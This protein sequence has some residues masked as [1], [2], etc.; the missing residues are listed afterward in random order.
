MPV[1]PLTAFASQLIHMDLVFSLGLV[2]IFYF[3]IEHEFSRS[4]ENQVA[5][6]RQRIAL[7]VAERRARLVE[8]KRAVVEA[9][10]RVFSEA[11]VEVRPGSFEVISSDVRFDGLCGSL[12][13]MV[14]RRL[15]EILDQE[16]ARRLEDYLRLR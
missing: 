1:Q 4:R 3:I 9:L 7:D 11:V 12:K 5:L 14:G 15:L 2:Q 16:D 13:S 10:L 8:A 6:E